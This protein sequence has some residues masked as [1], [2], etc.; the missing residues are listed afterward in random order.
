MHVKLL[1]FYEPQ[2]VFTYT[3]LH[4]S[5]QNF[6]FIIFSI[7]SSSS[8]S[9]LFHHHQLLFHYRKV[10][11]LNFYIFMNHK[12]FL[13]ILL[14]TFQ[15]KFYVSSFSLFHHHHLL[16]LLK[17]CFEMSTSSSP[18]QKGMHLKLQY[19]YEEHGFITY[20]SLHI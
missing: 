12:L 6:H 14:F 5:N 9:S 3:S 7:S 18:L 17:D 20:T 2:T 11:V 1:H 10:C 19:F 8:S 16:Y 13:P 4:I 15:I